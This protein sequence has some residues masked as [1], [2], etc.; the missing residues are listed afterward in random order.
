MPKKLDPQ[1]RHAAFMQLWT[2]LPY[3]KPKDKINAV[4]GILMCEANT[5]RIYSMK[6]SPRPIPER[7]LK[8]LQR[9]FANATNPTN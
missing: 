6:N 3:Q 9:H 5:V 8:I 4:T 1:Q 7:S 2:S